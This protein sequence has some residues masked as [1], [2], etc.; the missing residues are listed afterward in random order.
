[1]QDREIVAAIVAGEPGG[2]AAAYG[3]YAPALHAYCRSMLDEQDAA[4]AVQDTFIIAADK[5]AGLRDPDRLRPWLYAVARNEC[6]HRLRLRASAAHLDEAGVARA[7]AVTEETDPGTGAQRAELRVLVGAALAGMNP[8]DREIIELNLRHD[9][10]GAD[11]ADALG[12]PRN[13]AHALASRA[14]SHFET[15]LGALLVARS[16]REACPELASILSGWDG[17]MTPL[18]RKRIN[19]HIERCE[20]CG[21]RKRRELSPAMLLGLL[22]VAALP[23]ALREQVF[24]L[25][26]DT[27]PAAAAHRAQVVQR[28]G[29]FG[30]SGFPQPLDP[31]RSRTRR[32]SHLTSAAGAAAALVAIGAVLTF[33]L[34]HQPGRSPA[35]PQA[36]GRIPHVFPSPVVPGGTPTVSASPGA[37]GGPS[38]A[39]GVPGSPGPGASRSPGQPSPGSSPSPSGSGQPSPSP[40]TAPSSGPPPSPTP[41]PAPSPPAGT[42]TE[43]PATV[44]IS[45]SLSLS[46]LT[47]WT[48]TFTL[49]A[50]G[51]RV[52]H[53]TVTV[54]SRYSEEM[55]V[56]PASGS[57]ADGS[58]VTV[59]VR[60][61]V[62]G[63]F[64]RAKLTVS[65]G[66]ST[67][68]VCYSAL[69]G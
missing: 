27:S 3:R 6:R 14:R 52:G 62:G 68:T 12:V 5:L 26:S 50:H 69:G 36:A 60:A 16:G 47:W 65:P 55:T 56:S 25:V 49:T 39:P 48:G 29:Q 11:L 38:S 61:S 7:S 32:P 54:P 24:R 4:D 9:L 1:M 46:G 28:A 30:P 22:P 33:F 53:Y 2:L 57:L 19:R 44:Y 37:S 35:G 15:S 23:V 51:G 17:Q 67:V 42:L 43:S 40:S 20:R 8:S 66:N 31:P 59:T 58:S 41:T 34:M 21:E 13:Q 10:E 18:L 64:S 45:P 63:L